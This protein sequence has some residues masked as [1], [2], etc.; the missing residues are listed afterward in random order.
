ML[1]DTDISIILVIVWMT[2][3][4]ALYIIASVLAKPSQPRTREELPK[5]VSHYDNSKG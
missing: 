3:T 5:Y 4:V 1:E 2:V